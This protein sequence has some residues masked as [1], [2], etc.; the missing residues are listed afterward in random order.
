[1]PKTAAVT[2][3][4]GD[5]GSTDLLGARRLRKT[6]PRIEALGDLDE[7]TSAFG[8]ARA[9]VRG[10]DKEVLLE[11]QRGFYLV[12]A[13]VA[14]PKAKAAR[15]KARIDARAVAELDAL[16]ERLRGSAAVEPRF[17]VPGEDP[18]SA[19]L[20]VAR[21]V[22]RRAERAVVRLVDA[23]EIDGTHLLPW[24]N[25]ASDV[26]FLLARAL[27]QRRTEAKTGAITRRGDRASGRSSSPRR[28]PG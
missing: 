14:M 13:E 20:D 16:V 10:R 28:E 11:V 7:A 5:T 1:M 17:V 4:T 21:A 6:D 12:M 23:K 24:L 18:A 2:T 19:A 22:S 3:R 15:L 9:M 27:E 8:L 26:A 25:R